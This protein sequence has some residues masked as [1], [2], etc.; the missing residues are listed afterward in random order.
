MPRAW[1]SPRPV[2]IGLAL[3]LPALM[4]LSTVS[5]A[6]K[7]P[8]ADLPRLVW[9][10][11]MLDVVA[12]S[13]LLEI[14]LPRILLGV[15]AGMGL[16]VA[17]ATMQ[18]LFRNPLADPGLIGIS[19]GGALGAVAAIVVGGGALAVAP[20]AFLGA[21]AATLLGYRLGR[22]QAGMAGLLL[23]GIAINAVCASLIGLFTYLADDTQLRSLAFWNLGSLAGGSW[24]M[25]AWLG[26][27]TLLLSLL[28][29][30]EW[31]AMNA[32]LLGEREAQ[33]L[34]FALAALRRRLVLLTALL[35][36]PIVAATG[37]IG[38]VGL[39]VPHLLRLT[40]GADHRALLP[41]CAL[42]GACAL[43]LADWLARIVIVPAELPIGIVTSLVGGP[44]FLW[45]LAS[46]R[47]A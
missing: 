23:A 1:R 18:A 33:H 25:L 12:R 35:V 19:S 44:F 42:G 11:D 3:A 10:P 4:L 37:I 8:L 9:N 45:L 14:R 21:L 32:L 6:F 38:F 27:W 5:G 7:I 34:G 17:G 36:G 46:R 41:A 26:P 22:R 13:V 31:R 29:V 39:V 2:L 40:L 43:T 30:R 15:I 24:P 16:A 28:A 47:G 20:A